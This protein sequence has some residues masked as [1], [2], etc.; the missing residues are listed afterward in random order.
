MKVIYQI[1]KTVQGY[2]IQDGEGNSV[3]ETSLYED[4]CW[5]RNV[6]YELAFKKMNEHCEWAWQDGCATLFHIEI[7]DDKVYG[8][9]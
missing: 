7:R 2:E 3:P 6:M 9:R 8:G 5:A 4:I 1:V